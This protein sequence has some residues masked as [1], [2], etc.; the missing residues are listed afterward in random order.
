MSVLKGMNEGSSCN[1]VLLFF[2]SKGKGERKEE[3]KEG[4]KKGGQKSKHAA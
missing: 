2:C 1:L 4:V 3:R